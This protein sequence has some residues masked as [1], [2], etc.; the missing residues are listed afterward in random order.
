MIYVIKCIITL[1]TRIKSFVSEYK[2]L[3]NFRPNPLKCHKA[4]A[5]VTLA[6][7]GM[8]FAFSCSHEVI[9]LIRAVDCRLH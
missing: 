5:S 3:E 4:W 9:D 7:K 2:F 6:H 8:I 1:L